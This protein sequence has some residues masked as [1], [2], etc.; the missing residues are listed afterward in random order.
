[1]RPFD[2]HKLIPVSRII[3]F[4]QGFFLGIASHSKKK[5]LYAAK[6]E[7]CGCFQDV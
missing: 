7:V 3:Y 6:E 2:A 1:V 4:Y 5:N